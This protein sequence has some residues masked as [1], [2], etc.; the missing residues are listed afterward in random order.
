MGKY[1][2]DWETTGSRSDWRT[3]NGLE[4]LSVRYNGY[5]ARG[6]ANMPGEILSDWTY[7]L[8]RYEAIWI[9]SDMPSYRGFVS[10]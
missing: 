5:G 2:R 10:Y 6:R 7:M 8:V 9:I 4:H 3:W 1:A